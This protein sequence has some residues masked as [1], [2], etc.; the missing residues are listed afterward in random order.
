MYQPTIR[1]F[2]HVEQ[3]SASKPWKWSVNGGKLGKPI[4]KLYKVWS[5]SKCMKNLKKI[6]NRGKLFDFLV[7]MKVSTEFHDFFS[8]NC[9]FE[10]VLMRHFECFLNTVVVS[11]RLRTQSG[12]SSNVLGF[13]GTP[14][15]RSLSCP[16]MKC[17]WSYWCA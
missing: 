1:P 9:H 8:R 2:I 5:S 6:C 13:V 16:I 4:Y 17:L 3:K 14:K 15:R 7:K 10:E 11:F 12:D